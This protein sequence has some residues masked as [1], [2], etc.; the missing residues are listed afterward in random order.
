VKTPAPEAIL[1]EGVRRALLLMAKAIK[2]YTDAKY[3]TVTVTVDK[4][5]AHG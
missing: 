1:L 3:A 4:D 2:R 5:S